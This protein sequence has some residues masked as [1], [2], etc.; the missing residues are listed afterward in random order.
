M[1]DEDENECEEQQEEENESESV[2]K[3]VDDGDDV[4]DDRVATGEQ[5]TT[6]FYG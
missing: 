4:I 3:M 2:E 6:E 5:D 1:Y